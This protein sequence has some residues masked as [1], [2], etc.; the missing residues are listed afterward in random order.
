MTRVLGLSFGSCLPFGQFV[1]LLPPHK[2]ERID[3]GGGCG[4]GGVGEWSS[5]GAIMSHQSLSMACCFQKLRQL[6]DT[7]SLGILF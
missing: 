5:K 4:G 3:R 2:K 6:Y 1:P 7:K